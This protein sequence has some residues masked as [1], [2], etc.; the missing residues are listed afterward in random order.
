MRLAVLLTGLMG[1]TS[2]A[3]ILNDSTQKINI[4]TSNNTKTEVE[5]NGAVYNA[6]SIISVSRSKEDLI[7]NAKNPKCTQQYLVKSKVDNK[8]WIN[9]LSGGTFGSSTDYG[10]D[11]MWTY[12]DEVELKCN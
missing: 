8:F 1:L 10:S 5:I 9:I 2:C 6:P 12:Q 11:K 4:T 3:T 7:L